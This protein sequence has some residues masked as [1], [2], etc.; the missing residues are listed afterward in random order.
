[1]VARTTRILAMTAESD[2]WSTWIEG[3]DAIIDLLE[4]GDRAGA[5]LRYRQIYVD[6]RAKVE[7]VLFE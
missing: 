3:H 1:V 5:V 6:Y 2:L 4:A 7:A